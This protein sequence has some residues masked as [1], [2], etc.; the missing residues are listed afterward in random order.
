MGDVIKWLDYWVK[1]GRK[2]EQDFKRTPA[3]DVQ[4]QALLATLDGLSFDSIL[5]LGCGFGRVTQLL[6]GRYDVPVTALDISP[7]QLA[8]AALRVPSAEYIESSILGFEPA[9]RRWALVIAVEVLMHV[10]PS[11]IE[12]TVAKLRELSSAL[13]VTVDYDGPPA[14]LSAHNWAHDYN[15]LFPE[16]ERTRVGRQ[17]ISVVRL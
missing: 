6:A 12:A 4:E 3:F 17:S 5:E 13:I 1:R 9:P 10:P 7:D 16:A 15:A 8:A 2:Y 14:G 11:E